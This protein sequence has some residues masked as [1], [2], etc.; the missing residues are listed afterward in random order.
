MQ[1]LDSNEVAQQLWQFCQ[2]EQIEFEKFSRSLQQTYL[3]LLTRLFTEYSKQS[4]KPFIV[5]LNAAQGAGKSTLSELLV[6][7][8]KQCFNLKAIHF[9]IDDF[10]FNQKQRE[11]LANEIHPL[12]QTRGVPGTHNLELL[13]AIFSQLVG[14]STDYP[15]FIPR[16]DKATDN[17]KP[18]SDWQKVEQQPDIIIFEGWCVGSLALSQEDLVSPINSLEDE[19]DEDRIW[20]NYV[21][22]QLQEYHSVFE[23]IDFLIFLQAP[24]FETVYDWRFEQE[25]KLRLSLQTEDE[26]SNENSELTDSCLMDAEQIKNFILYFERITKHNLETLPQTANLVISLDRDRSPKIS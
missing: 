17:P 7:L 8:F 21:N 19:Y 15:I 23:T 4:H 20:R 2:E 12:L 3:P 10:Y 1:S 25:E 14:G 18:L 5:G 24:S 22:N 6:L 11:K 9:S 26:L 13:L 16:F